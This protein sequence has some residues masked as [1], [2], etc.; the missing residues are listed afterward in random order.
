MRD[1][2]LSFYLLNKKALGHFEKDASSM[3]TL[4]RILMLYQQ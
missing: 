1:K 4:M 3:R 2:I